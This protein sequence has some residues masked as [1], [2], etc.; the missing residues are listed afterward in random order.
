VI[1]SRYVCFFAYLLI[2][3]I[4]VFHIQQKYSLLI[5]VILFVHESSS[6]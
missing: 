4:T 3:L 1:V 6:I 2:I 5:I